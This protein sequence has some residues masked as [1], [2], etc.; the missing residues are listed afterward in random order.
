RTV[1]TFLS[2]AEF[3]E[4]ID[5]L[6]M[7]R[8]GSISQT[9]QD[10]EDDDDVD[11]EERRTQRLMEFFKERLNHN[12]NRNPEESSSEDE[13]RGYEEEEKMINNHEEKEKGTVIINNDSDHDESSYCLSNS[14]PTLHTPSAESSWSYKDSELNADE[15]VRVAYISSQPE[16]PPPQSECSWQHSRQFSSQSSTPSSIEMDFLYDMRGQMSQLF[17]EMSE[18]RNSINSCISMQMQLQ[19][20]MQQFKNQDV[21]SAKKEE[22]LSNNNTSKKGKCCICN[23]SKVEA[24]L[25]RCGHMCACLKCANELQRKGENCPICKTPVVDVVR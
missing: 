25:Y 14:S 20:Q 13:A 9:L 12:L 4:K 17:R 2:T 18:L 24:V 3:R 11:F 5:R 21:Y 7:S 15:F 6:M 23:E 22:K 1:S 19:M 16:P 8:T 10:E